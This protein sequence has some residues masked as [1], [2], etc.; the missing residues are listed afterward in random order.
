M[1][2]ELNV[3]RLDI[4]LDCPP[5][6]IGIDVSMISLVVDIKIIKV[7]QNL[8]VRRTQEQRILTLKNKKVSNVAKNV[9]FFCQ[10]SKSHLQVCELKIPG[11]IGN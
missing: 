9:N 6:L 2:L 4:D 11:P 7:G 1:Y 3:T 8:K 10:G 5:G